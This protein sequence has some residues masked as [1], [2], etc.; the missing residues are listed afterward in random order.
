MRRVILLTLVLS[1]AGAD[2]ASGQSL[3][4]P[5]PFAGI[6]DELRIGLQAY[7]VHPAML[8]FRVNEWQFSELK[9]ISF[10]VLFVSPELDAFRWIGSPRP[11]LGTTFSLTGRESLFHGGLTWQLPIFDTPLYL[12]GTFGAAIHDGK[13]VGAAAPTKNFGC[14]VLFYERFGVG[15]NLTENATATLSYEHVSNNGWCPENAGLS[16]FGFRLGWKF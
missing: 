7:D 8:P 4:D 11:E 15:A 10:D 1:A 16:N 3:L 6:V 5:N 9:S 2:A 13:L 12:E 14:R